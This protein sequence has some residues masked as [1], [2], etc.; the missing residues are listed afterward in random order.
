VV[1][2]AAATDGNGEPH[3]VPLAYSDLDDWGADDHAAAFSAF[4][5]S[6]IR[7]LAGDQPV[8]AARPSEPGLLPICSAALNAGAPAAEA[9]RAFFERHF[10]PFEVVPPSGQG[11]LTGYY[12]PEFLARRDPDDAFAVPL[13]ERPGDL[14][15]IPPGETLP[16]IGPSLQAARR[17]PSGGFEAYP[18]RPAIEDG[19]LGPEEKPIAYLREPGEAFIAQVQGSARLRLPDG[20]VMRLAYAGRNGHPY[21]S[22]G[23]IL[24]E[25]GDIPLAEMSLERLMDWLR[26][27]PSR[28]RELMR[29]NRSYVFFREARELRPDDGP[30]GGAGTSLVPGR[31]LAVDRTLWSYGLPFWLEGTLPVDLDHGEPLRRLLIAHDTGSAILGPARGDFFVGSGPEAGTRAALMRHETRFVVLKPRS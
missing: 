4:R 25:R 9:A 2:P 11:F 5:R 7:L 18:D 29:R 28:A 26:A 16:G 31:S 20:T 3:L 6:C 27:H 21:S 12:E 8:R 24:V 15:T 19:A 17:L 23:R 14:V 30:I 13:L 10:D 1:A 22:I